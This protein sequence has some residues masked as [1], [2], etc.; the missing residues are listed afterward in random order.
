MAFRA[1]ALGR[2]VEAVWCCLPIPSWRK[3]GLYALSAVNMALAISLAVVWVLV[4]Q[5]GSHAEWINN[6]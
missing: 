2:F 6:P 4:F 5:S 1:L 3:A